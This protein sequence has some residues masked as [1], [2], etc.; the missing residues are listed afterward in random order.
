MLDFLVRPRESDKFRGFSYRKKLVSRSYKY[1]WKKTGRTETRK[2]STIA[3][4]VFYQDTHLAEF[5]TLK[6]VKHYISEKANT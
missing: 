3:W 6:E 2:T 5:D 1:T 4:D